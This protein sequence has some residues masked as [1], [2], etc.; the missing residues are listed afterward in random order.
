MTGLHATCTLAIHPDNK[1][2]PSHW[3]I[4]TS[5]PGYPPKDL[6]RF[7]FFIFILSSLN[8]GLSLIKEYTKTKALSF[9]TS[10]VYPI[11]KCITMCRLIFCAIYLSSLLQIHC[12]CLKEI[13]RNTREITNLKKF[14]SRNKHCCWNCIPLTY[15]FHFLN[16]CL[17]N[18]TFVYIWKC[19]EYV[20]ILKSDI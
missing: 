4:Q 2:L 13:K 17:V 5:N 3:G 1:N 18:P 10:I 7:F 8:A 16:I 15:K 11:P 12:C 14:N 19:A 6:V 20:D 9:V